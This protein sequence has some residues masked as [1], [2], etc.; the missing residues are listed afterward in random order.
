MSQVYHL[1]PEDTHRF[2]SHSVLYTPDGY[3]ILPV[4]LPIPKGYLCGKC[5]EREALDVAPACV[6]EDCPVRAEQQL[7]KGGLHD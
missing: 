1:K 2:T 5:G 4:D 7:R 6:V 3:L